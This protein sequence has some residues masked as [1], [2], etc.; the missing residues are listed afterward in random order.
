[1]GIHGGQSRKCSSPRGER[2]TDTLKASRQYRNTANALQNTALANVFVPADVHSPFQVRPRV[3]PAL[4]WDLLDPR[5]PGSVWGPLRSQSPQG[6]G[7]LLRSL[8]G[9]V[10]ST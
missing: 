5:A 1:M 9:A 2:T 8:L 7:T 4:P 10:L 6:A 3:G